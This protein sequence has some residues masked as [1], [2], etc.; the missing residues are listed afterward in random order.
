MLSY[1]RNNSRGT[2][3]VFA[4]AL[5][6]PSLLAERLGIPLSYVLPDRSG[7]GGLILSL[8][9]LIPILTG[10]L[11]LLLTPETFSRVLKMRYAWVGLACVATDVV[12]YTL[13]GVL[14]R[15][16]QAVLALPL[17]AT[18][19]V[20]AILTGI[21]LYRALPSAIDWLL[22]TA[23]TLSA[24]V[25]G[26]QTAE[27]LGYSTLPGSLIV[28]W[29]EASAE[30]LNTVI[31]WR[32][33][34]G[35][36]MNPNMYTPLAIVG[37]IWALFGTA[38]GPLRWVILAASS[39]VAVF[40]QSRTT[41]IVLVLLLVIA[42]IKRFRSSGRRIPHPA[43]VITGVAS[44]LVAAL[45]VAGVMAGRSS[46]GS[47]FSLSRAVATTGELL[48]NPF[49]DPS[50]VART[51]GWTKA[52]DAIARNPWGYFHRSSKQV[53]PLSHAHNEFLYRVL[54]AGPLWLLAHLVFLVWLWAWLR[55][56]RMSAIGVAIAVALLVNGI[57]EPLA[58]MHPFTVLLYLIIGAAM[59]S[60]AEETAP[61]RAHSPR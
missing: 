43:L 46:E 12:V 28:M 36:A 17:A 9:Y 54:Y 27:Y 21:A 16:F 39:A 22:A 37:F 55:P 38:K 2:A 35:F 25:G 3:I 33:A 48:A 61:D 34:E 40:G 44:V 4:A 49:A 50:I 7:R 32:R 11:S 14:E 8:L 13:S 45:L 47:S 30:R 19:S 51:A 42:L 57:T 20:G 6:L 23:T 52:T 60:I 26:F 31:A 29:D 5:L 53:A 56:R 58:R 24:V 10:A 15:S 18:A 41:L 1:F 59:W